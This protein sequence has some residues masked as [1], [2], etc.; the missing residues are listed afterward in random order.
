MEEE[1]LTLTKD[2]LT[3]LRKRFLHGSRIQEKS[4]VRVSDDKMEAWMYLAEPSEEKGKYKVDDLLEMLRNEGVTTGYMMPRLVAMSKKGV[5]QR[6]ILVAK[7]KAV[8]EGNDGYYEYFFTP[9]ELAEA[10]PTIREDGSVDYSS[11]SALQSVKEGDMLAK[12]Y[13]AVAG[14]DGYRVDGEVLKST[15]VKELQPL[16]GL[17]PCLCF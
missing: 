17:H 15:P 7:G 6:E 10:A 4:Y 12:Y 14:E 5:Y 9:D 3:E 13:L 16:R 11:M 1:I 8:I 2:Q